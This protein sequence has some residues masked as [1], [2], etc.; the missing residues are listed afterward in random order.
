MRKGCAITTAERRH[1][2]ARGRTARTWSWV[3]RRLLPQPARWPMETGRERRTSG[4]ISIWLRQIPGRKPT[5]GDL[6]GE[7]KSFVRIADQTDGAGQASQQSDFR[8]AQGRSA[9]TGVQNSSYRAVVGVLNAFLRTQRWLFQCSS[10]K[11]ICVPS[12]ARSA[13]R[14]C[15][16]TSRGRCEAARRRLRR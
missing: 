4:V 5:S 3:S 6:S 13:A 7:R 9:D 11:T 14:G 12:V 16:A 2:A 8:S 10:V 1:G 15:G